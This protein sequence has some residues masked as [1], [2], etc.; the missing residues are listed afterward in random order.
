[1]LTLQRGDWVIASR[2]HHCLDITLREEQSRVRTPKAARALGTI[3]RVVVSWANA[4][5]D[6]ARQNQPKTK[7]NTASF[8]KRFTSARGG[9]ERLH[10]LID[11]K[12]PKV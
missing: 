6:Q 8:P 10:A 2:R 9:R 11:A 3:R 7:K 12:S 1:M 5:V 4:A